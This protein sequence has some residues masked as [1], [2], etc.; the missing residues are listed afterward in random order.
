[1][2]ASNQQITKRINRLI[3][4]LPSIFQ[5]KPNFRAVLSAIGQSDAEL[6][7]LFLEVRKQLFVDTAEGQY[8]DMLG[9][10][11][12]VVRPPLVGM[13]DEDF[14]EFIKL[15]TYH[16]KQIK[17]LLFRLMELFYGRDTIKA[18]IRSQ[19]TG[20]YSILSTSNL[21]IRVDES[22]DIIEIVFNASQFNDPNNVTSAELAAQINAQAP[23]AI[24]GA[25][26]YNAIDK[27]E[28]LEVYTNTFGPVGSITVVGGTANRFLKFPETMRLGATVS[29]QYRLVK[30]TTTMKLY[31]AGSDN[32]NFSLLRAG[33]SVLLTGTPFSAE[34]TGSFLVGDIVDTGI[35]AAILTASSAIFQSPNVVRYAMASTAGI[36]SGSNVTIDGFT[37]ASNNGVFVVLTVAGGYIDVQSLRVT[38]T[39]DEVAAGTVDLIEDASYI[40]FINENGLAQSLF[41]VISTDDV[42]FFRPQKRKLESATRVATAWEI[43]SNEIVITLPAT[44]VVVRRELAGS[45][46]AQGTVAKVLKAFYTTID[47]DAPEY[48]PDLLGNFYLQKP[49]GLL[50]RDVKYK[51]AV[52]S[53]DTL[54][55]VTPTINPIGDKLALGAG[56]LSAQIG[57][58]ILTITTADRHNLSSG[59]LTRFANF[60]GFAG[61]LESEINGLRVVVSVIDDFTFTVAASNTA[62]STTTNYPS[63]DKGEI[64]TTHNCKVVLTNV[65]SNTGYV[66][67]YVYD[68]KNAP[69]TVS[70]LKTTTLQALELGAFAGALQVSDS[71]VFPDSSGEL[72]I[73]YGQSDQEGPVKYIAKPSAGAIYLD[74]SYRFEKSHAANSSIN[75]IR[76]RL[77]TE[78]G[79]T[80][81]NYPVYI[82][83]T[84]SPRETLKDLLLDAKAAGVSVRFVIYLP[85]NVYNAFSIYE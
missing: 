20:P 32:P 28:F 23:N 58:N 30:Q 50:V 62:S 27:Q 46:H 26:Y 77:A 25:T 76:S 19:A 60:N 43:N 59:E 70:E 16:P 78:P 80:G 33:D 52:K 41:N 29:T 8:L 55:N 81:K 85:E 3:S 2:T 47:L 68:P 9:S 72:I 22:P 54:I 39:D 71:S 84:I 11:S 36:M 73:N 42:L 7:N 14:R 5:D 38:N 45:A 75:L 17:L 4:F 24:F 21:L 48:F 53:G 65:Q 67:S 31:W 15:Q 51:Y 66:G 13:V 35:P 69:Y 83:D 82:V 44:P 63:I 18:S 37:N 56:A 6:E 12:G 40:S 34:N 49:N 74:P 1:M 61:L 10:N 79:A 57:S 64:F